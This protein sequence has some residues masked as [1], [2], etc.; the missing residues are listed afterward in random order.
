MT[1]VKPVEERKFD[2][3]LGLIGFKRLA[4]SYDAAG[5]LQINKKTVQVPGKTEEVCIAVTGVDIGLAPTGQGTGRYLNQLRFNATVDELSVPML[6]FS[7]RAQMIS[8]QPN[9][10]WKGTIWLTILCFGKIPE[11]NK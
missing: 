9:D 10:Q 11:P 3:P 7:L 2:K 8:E 6:K 1:D 5:E 4:V